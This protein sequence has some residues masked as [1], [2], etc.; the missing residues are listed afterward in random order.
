MKQNPFSFL[1]P[2]GDS[3]FAG[4]AL[5]LLAASLIF[6]NGCTQLTQLNQYYGNEGGETKS[7]NIISADTLAANQCPTGT[8]ECTCLVCKNNTPT[9]SA[10]FNKLL[11]RFF[12]YTLEGG[13]CKFSSCTETEFSEGFSA[14]PDMH[15]YFFMIGQGS[16]FAEFADATTYCNNSLRMAVKWLASKE[17]YDYP[18]PREDR[19]RC[20]LDKNAIPVYVLYSGGA[21]MNPN[22]AGQ[23]AAIFKESGPVILV[24]EMDFDPL[25]ETQISDAKEQAIM[26]KANC[27]KC[28]IAIAPRFYYNETLGYGPSYAAIDE[29]FSDPAAAQ[30]IDL[31]AV[32]VNSHYAKSCTSAETLE[33]ALNYSRYILLNH[34]KPTLWA[35]VLFDLDWNAGGEAQGTC[36]W[37]EGEVTKG[38]S[39]LFKY[40]PALV[41]AGVIGMAPYSLYG[42]TNGPLNCT[43]C[44]M[45]SVD[46][47]RYPSHTDWFSL[48]QKYYT[49]RG[50]MPIV[51]TSNPGTDCSF[52][53]NFNLYQLESSR[54]GSSPTIED[55]QGQEIEPAKTFFRCSG[56]L[57]TKIPDE[58][59][60]IPSPGSPSKLQCKMHPMLDMFAD[61]RDMD[62]ALTRAIAWSET[63][64]DS[65]VQGPGGDTC[66]ISQVDKSKFPNLPDTITD[67]EGV[68]GPQTA[69][70]GK[71]FHSIGLMQV[72]MYP[73]T[74]WDN[75]NYQVPAF[76]ADAKWCG[77]DSFN[78]F[79][80]D[81]NACL[82]TAILAKYLDAAKTVISSKEPDLGLSDLKAKYGEESEQYQDMKG[83]LT[84]F[85]AAY[86]YNG[87]STY[88]NNEQSWISEFGL[89]R[90][91]NATYCS[92][93]PG[94]A[95]CDSKGHIINN[96]CCGVTNF[97]DY[98]SKCK[99][100]TNTYAY[101]VLGEYRALMNGCDKYNQASWDKN[102]GDY[103]SNYPEIQ[104]VQ[105][106]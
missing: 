48:C 85:A 57:L 17:G 31:V 52:G 28:L 6:L 23:I 99:K 55:L 25:N 69:S 24:S 22:R 37:S 29:I 12:D 38:Y 100:P 74:M 106:P 20:I 82:G 19:A 61:I 62:P 95:C 81:H 51:F 49:Y 104:V 47:V 101:N 75:P 77:G 56:Q 90:K 2:R 5:L 92:E 27:P 34:T 59:T 83:V 45:M 46:G 18:L 91:I 4:F 35:Y 103:L 84:I 54:M 39:D 65:E 26:M 105:S 88:T 1:F 3:G 7:G 43:N 13:E 42:L 16:N 53:N 44:G 87:F 98:V 78:P 96:G 33:D 66:E 68:C 36:K 32:G 71:V 60:T 72:H 89:Q 73:A 102:V 67:P 64:L 9:N 10:F 80:E 79:R 94:T 14:S 8:G 40:S 41:Q 15:P 70:P 21:A 86:R 76:E 63:G 11:S 58:I 97:I 93:N 30:S 50:A